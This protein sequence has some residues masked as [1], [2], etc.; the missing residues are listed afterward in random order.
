MA[1]AAAQDPAAAELWRPFVRRFLGLLLGSLLAIVSMNFLVNPMGL[2]PPHWLPPVTW[3]TRTIKPEL[4]QQARPKPQVMILGSSRS[5][6]I[7]PAEVRQITGLPTFNAAVDSAMAEDYYLMLRYAV[8]RAG[9][10]PKMVL[11]GVDVEAFHNA[12][13]VDDRVFEAEAFRE[14]LPG[15]TF[16]AWKMFYK[17]FVHQQ[18]HLALR[19]LRI[20]LTG[21]FPLRDHF[22]PD[23][24]LHY[25]D[26][27]K[28]R[29][30]GHYDVNA[31]IQRNVAWYVERTAGYTAISP[32][33]QKYLEELLQYCHDRNIKVVMWVTP[34][35]PR[36]LETL[37]PRGYD[38]REREVLAMLQE[39][40]AKYGAEVY[41]FSAVEKFG[42]DPRGFWD[43]AHMTEQ[44]NALVTRLMLRRTDAVQ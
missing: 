32:E 15:H 26:Y 40:G 25:G 16:W 30:T 44:N 10:A 17:L 23:G 9:I 12:R 33:R 13:P 22:D 21:H 39:E 43:G 28:E 42:G 41:D 34:L 1:T 24:Y 38:Q 29:A 37:G 2:Y 14:L 36:L 3:N 6:Q 4:L 7:A 35:G 18:T 19:S 31:K 20:Q 8:E 11:L 27:E 5:M